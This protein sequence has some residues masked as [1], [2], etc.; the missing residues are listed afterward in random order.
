MFLDNIQRIMEL[1]ELSLVKNTV[2]VICSSCLTTL[3]NIME[4]PFFFVI[5][6]LLRDRS[7]RVSTDGMCSIYV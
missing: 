4:L 5:L 2:V 6:L 7:N 3:H 1:T